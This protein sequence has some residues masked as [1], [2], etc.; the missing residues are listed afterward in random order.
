MANIKG[1]TIDI[2]G[3]TSKLEDALKNVN[4]VVYSTNTELRQLNQALKLDPKNTELLSQKQ[5][6]LKNN[7]KATTDRLNTLKEAQKQMGSYSSLT[8]EQ[9]KSTEL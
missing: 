9:K 2:G 3:N 5:D 8:E 6:V 1:I 4:K 7:I